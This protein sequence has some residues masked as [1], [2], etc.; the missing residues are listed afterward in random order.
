M[1]LGSL[2]TGA[3]HN[4]ALQE[5]EF[6]AERAK[7]DDASPK[8]RLAAV[9]ARKAG[10]VEASVFDQLDMNGEAALACAV[11]AQM[12][13][14]DALTTQACHSELLCPAWRSRQSDCPVHAEQET[15]LVTSSVA[16][17]NACCVQVT[18]HLAAHAVLHAGSSHI[19]C[20]HSQ[21]DLL[22]AACTHPAAAAGLASDG[23]STLPACLS[24]KPPLALQAPCAPSTPPATL[25][26]VQVRTGNSDSWSAAP[27]GLL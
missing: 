10:V 22:I 20:V 27:D 18:C 8:Q 9:K 25:V 24:G 3:K 7:L 6:A 23:L 14:L 15:L 12:G 17:S 21:Q 13:S 16:A 11:H 26:Y 1:V 19:P 4:V 5:K 2:V